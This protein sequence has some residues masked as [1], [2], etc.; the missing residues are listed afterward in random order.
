MVSVSN[1]FQSAA[2]AVVKFWIAS[3]KLP[4]CSAMFASLYPD[5]LA[6]VTCILFCVWYSRRKKVLKL[7]YVFCASGRPIHSRY[8]MLYLPVLKMS[9]SAALRICAGVNAAF[10]AVV[11]LLQSSICWKITATGRCDC[12]G[13]VN[14]AVLFLS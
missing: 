10:P 5:W 14:L 11:N 9:D 6:V 7:L 1:A 8:A 13:S 3:C 12:T 2:D 4:W